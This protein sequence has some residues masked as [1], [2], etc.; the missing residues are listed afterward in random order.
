MSKSETFFLDK[1]IAFSI[2]LRTMTSVW[3]ILYLVGP[4][5]IISKTCKRFLSLN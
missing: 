3:S 5:V 4:S 2:K 1:K